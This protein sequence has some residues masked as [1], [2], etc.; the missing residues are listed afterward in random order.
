M[1]MEMDGIYR[2]NNLSIYENF[3]CMDISKKK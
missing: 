3:I 1:E 2:K